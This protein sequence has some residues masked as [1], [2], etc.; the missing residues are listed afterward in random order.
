MHTRIRGGSGAALAST[1]AA[2]YPRSGAADHVAQ[3]GEGLDK[4][5]AF[6]TALQ[7]TTMNVQVIRLPTP[8][9]GDGSPTLRL[10]AGRRGGPL[11][12]Q[13]DVVVLR[14][15][16]TMLQFQYTSMDPSGHEQFASLAKLAVDKF[17]KSDQI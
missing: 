1:R 17:R 14:G 6:T 13:T 12:L 15:G 4:C 10:S 9:F 7:G 5:S 8:R 16:D 11:H 3:V 2:A